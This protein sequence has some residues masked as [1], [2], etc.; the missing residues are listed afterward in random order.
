M[1]I[2]LALDWTPNTMHAGY[3][4]A[5]AE[6]YFKADQLDVEFITPEDDNYTVTPAKKL[7]DKQVHVAV[8]PSESVISFNTLPET[9]PLVAIAAVLQDDASAIV[10]RSDSVVTRPARLD[11]KTFASYRARF[12]DDI[13]RQLVRAEGGEGTFTVSTPERLEM[14]RAVVDG[15]ADA[16]WVFL[17]WEGVLAQHQHNI[18]FNA[19]RL[20]DYRIPYGYSPLLITHQDF[21][22]QEPDMLQIFLRAVEKGWR[23]VHD[24]PGRAAEILHMHISHPN[25]QDLTIVE[26]SLTLLQPSILGSTRRWGFMDGSRWLAW[27]EWML[28]TKVLKDT[29]GAPLSP[30]Q[31]D[32]SMLYTNDF[33]K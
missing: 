13:V 32:T 31:I 20:K 24:R 28:G 26:D 23:F 14:W 33:F 2:N 21:I 27:V 4:I 18:T 3:F 15:S 19:F 30:G 12:E 25:F 10:T 11:G 9:I 17:P 6:G 29:S 7:A 8:A 22:E 5:E 16:T 1:K